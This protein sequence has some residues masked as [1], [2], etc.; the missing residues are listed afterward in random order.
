MSDLVPKTPQMRRRLV[1]HSLGYTVLSCVIVTMFTMVT[2]EKAEWAWEL[3]SGNFLAA[4]LAFPICYYTGSKLERITQLSEQLQALVERDRLTDVAT[5]DFFFTKLAKAPDAFG[6]SLMV[7]IDHFKEVNDQY[8]HLVGDAVIQSVAKAIRSS[9]RETD[10]VC[11]F[12]GE[13]FVIFLSEANEAAAW[14]M[15][16][17]MRKLVEQKGTVVDGGEV[18]VTVSVGGSMKS[19]LEKIEDAI[20]RADACLYE[21][22]RMG[23]N[24]TI[25]D[26]ADTHERAIA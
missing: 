10:V 9:V 2:Y 14:A 24:Q 21:A 19:A 4:S 13:E 6:V 17:R 22:K 12:G 20:R 5:R 3:M 25:V 18:F 15:A 11:R 1:I 26:W 16:E 7:D 23:R 8:G